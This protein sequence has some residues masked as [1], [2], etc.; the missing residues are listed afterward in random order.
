MA[1]AGARGDPH[2]RTY[3]LARPVKHVRH[4]FRL[5][6]IAALLAPTLAVARPELDDPPPPPKDDEPV[7][8]CNGKQADVTV[9]FKPDTEV[10]DLLTWAFGFTCKRFIYEPRVIANKH[11]TL[12]APGKVSREEAYELF[13]EAMAAVGVA[14]VPQHGALHLVDA[15][16][17]KHEPIPILKQLPPASEQVVRYVVKPTYVQASTVMQAFQT[18]K[19]DAGDLQVVGQLLLVADYASHVRDMQSLLALVDVP[20]GSDG[21]YTIPIEHADA[22]K[23][24]AEIDKVLATAAAPAAAAAKGGPA[25]AAANPLATPP[26]LTVDE[27]TNTLIVAASEAGYRRV[28]AIVDRIDVALAMEDGASLHVYPLGSAIATELA[29]TLTAAISRQTQPTAAPPGATKQQAAQ[30]STSNPLDALPT[31][32]GPVSVVGDKSSN[33]LLV[34]ASAHDYLALKDIIKQ[35]DLPRR[36]VYIEAMILEVSVSDGLTLGTS[37]HAG[38]SAGDG[39]VLLGGVQTGSGSTLDLATST[40]A[41]SLA[42][43]TGLIA[44]VIGKSLAGSTTLL[45]TSIPSYAV[46]FNALATAGNTEVVSEPSII[47]LDNEETKYKVGSN[48]PYQKGLSFPTATS[49]SSPFNSVGTNIDRKDLVLELDIKPHISIDDTVLLEVKHSSDDL[50]DKDATLGPTWSTRTIETRAVVRDQHTIVIG[51]LMQTKDTVT[52]NQ[53]PVLGSIPVLGNLF[54]YTVKSK[55]KTDL[56]ILLTPYIIRDQADLERIRERKSRQHAEFVRSNDF[57]AG[58]KYVSAIDYSH[59]R[60]VIEEINRAVQDVEHDEALRGSGAAKPPPVTTG[61]V[62]MH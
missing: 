58:A 39:S 16:T 24:A 19:S 27:R 35:L 18:V 6:L 23:I 30:P 20:G 40:G 10:K 49:G 29:Q 4:V 5:A 33:S 1:R 48:I 61:P 59:K 9:T 32:E 31:L 41:A 2:S 55:K 51:G 46:L 8:H 42:S 11:V 15:Q 56:L 7:F 21:I 53:V 62:E 47:V 44:G 60:G 43:M 54:K 37:S 38:Y 12:V 52:S 26:K 22:S 17:A 13:V 36:Q 14:I 34:T 25:E 3:A 28:K 57:L 50:A 45:G